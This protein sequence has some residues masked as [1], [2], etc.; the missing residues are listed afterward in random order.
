MIHDYSIMEATW[1]QLL[2]CYL[3]LLKP[4]PPAMCQALAK[5]CTD[6]A[7]AH[8]LGQLGQGLEAYTEWLQQDAPAA[9]F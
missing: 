3:D 9:T 7:Q 1:W 5:H 2:S 6:S 8:E 4:P